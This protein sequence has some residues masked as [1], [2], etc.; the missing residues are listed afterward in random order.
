MKSNLIHS[1][2]FGFTLV[3]L[4]VVIAVMTILASISGIAFR[5][6]AADLRMSSAES[7]LTASLDNARSIA[8]QKNRYVMAVFIPRLTADKTEQVTDIILAQWNGDSMNADFPT[9][10]GSR[11]WTVDRFVPVQGVEV[12]S[13][14]GGVSVAAPS[15][16]NGDDDLWLTPTYLPDV[17]LQEVE[18]YRGRV[19]AVMYSPEG[20]V[21]V[22]NAKSSADRSWVDF[23]LDGEQTYDPDPDRNPSTDDAYVVG[24]LTQTPDPETELYNGWASYLWGTYLNGPGG[25]PM[26]MTVPFVAVY[27][28]KEFRT[29]YPPQDWGDWSGRIDLYTKYINETAKRIQFNRYSGVTLR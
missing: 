1:R 14:E 12:R 4:I 2:K 27:D 26:V 18:D 28:E 6:I 13:I 19:S 22:R 9:G 21:V 5:R 23:N 10:S 11:I 29:L 8:I 3:E 16:H 24:W 17:A 25:E 7:T 20:R 15:Y